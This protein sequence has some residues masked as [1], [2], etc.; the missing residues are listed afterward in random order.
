MNVSFGGAG[1]TIPCPPEAVFL[2]HPRLSTP[3]E[4]G[5]GF[6]VGVGFGEGLEA[7][8]VFA[9]ALVGVGVVAAGQGSVSG[10]DF[11]Q[12][13]GFGEAE[14]GERL[15]VFSGEAGGFG[16]AG[17]GGGFPAQDAEQVFHPVWPI[18]FGVVG[19]GAGFAVPAGV[20]GLGLEDGVLIHAFEIVPAGVEGADVI[21]AEILPLRRAGWRGEC[22]SGAVEG[23]AIVSGERTA[24]VGA[25]AIPGIG[26]A[27]RSH[28]GVRLLSGG[29][30]ADGG[31]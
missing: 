25:G 10:L 21:E 8:F 5:A 3:L 15:A 13:G 19:E 4:G 11:G 30:W 27:F 23:C 22:A 6:E 31:I 9:A 1:D 28:D 18:L 26:S 17:G 2:S 20:G 7:G 24:R 14:F 29:C 16:F 12:R